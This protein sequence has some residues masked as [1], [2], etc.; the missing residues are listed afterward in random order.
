MNELPC[1]ESDAAVSYNGSYPHEM[2]GQVQHLLVQLREYDSPCG[3][4]A[5][6]PPA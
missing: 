5:A 4:E 6:L 3:A 2:Q 1:P